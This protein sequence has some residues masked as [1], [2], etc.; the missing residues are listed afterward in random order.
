[1]PT[2]GSLSDDT[3]VADDDKYLTLDNDGTAKNTPALTLK[4][5]ILPNGGV[6]GWTT[7]T[8]VVTVKSPMSISAISV[9]W[10]RYRKVG[11]KLEI[12]LQVNFT[13]GG[14]A[15][16]EIYVEPPIAWDAALYGA[17]SFNAGQWYGTSTAGSAWYPGIVYGLQA[18]GKIVFL[19]AGSATYST[20]SGR[21]IKYRG[22]YAIA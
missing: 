11:K 14:T 10:A 21:T 18:A 2:L 9:E 6:L 5:Y 22:E 17:S 1:M 13:L 3:T 12:D 7:F 4:N 19:N 15:S 16:N 8:P 20:G